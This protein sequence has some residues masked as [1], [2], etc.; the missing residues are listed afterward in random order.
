MPARIDGEA[1]GSSTRR[2]RAPGG[3][4]SASADSRT[5]GGDVGE[6]G[7]RV[8]HDRQQAVEEQRHDGRPRADAEQRDH[9]HQQ[10]QRRD[11]LDHARQREHHLPQPR[12]PGRED[13]QRHR[14][15]RWPRAS[16]MPTRNRCSRVWRRRIRAARPSAAHRRPPAPSSRSQEV[17]RHLP[18]RGLRSSFARA[19]SCRSSPARRCGP[20]AARARPRPRARARPG[21]R[22]TAARRRTSG[23]CR[24]S[25]SSTRRS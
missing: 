23:K 7:G 4:P 8:A 15:A 25:S 18:P 2:R 19:F 16:E 1:S 24:R 10:R 11:R 22:G 5:G 12:P 17:G 3:R 9:E 21:R 13:A 14:H 20:P 6:P